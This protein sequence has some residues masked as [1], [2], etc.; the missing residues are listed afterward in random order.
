MPLYVFVHFFLYLDLSQTKVMSF[1]TLPLQ[2]QHYVDAILW[3][4]ISPA[5]IIDARFTIIKT[6]SLYTKQFS[7]G[8]IVLDENIKLKIAELIT[9]SEDAIEVV[10]NTTAYTL[11][12]KQLHTDELFA[13]VLKNSNNEGQ[14]KNIAEALEEKVQLRTVQLEQLRSFLNSILN[15]AYFGIANYEPV[16]TN[17]KITDFKINYTNQE[18]PGNFG[19]NA[20]TVIGKTFKEVY[21]G[22]FENGVFNKLKNSI[23]TQLPDTYE[24]EVETENKKIW[25]TAAIEHVNGTLTVTSKNITAEKEFALSLEKMND[26]LNAKN[27]DLASFAYIASHDLQ[28][29]IRKIRM[30]TSRILEKD[31]ANFT[32]ESE[33]YLN[34][35]MHT[36]QRMHDLVKDLLLYSKAD[37]QTPV[38]QKTNLNDL[39]QE[40]VITMQED[41]AEI[42]AEIN[43]QELPIMNVIPSQIRQV[44]FNILINAV[45][46]RR[47]N[48]P[49]QITVSGTC[50]DIDD[51]DYYKISFQDNGIGFN[52]NYKDRIFDVFQRLHGRNEYEGSG[53]GL[54]ICK[55]IMQN[56]NG[57]I[58]AQSV[59]GE[60]SVFELY[61][62]LRLNEDNL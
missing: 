43:I 12:I 13:I 36:T 37:A 49:L 46:Y 7:N 41:L 51:T 23:I 61:F 14:Y 25:L 60:G 30:F 29:P 57:T 18:V 53:V 38:I 21:P 47:Y 26:V 33:A 59:L 3:A 35:I 52:D 56:H 45:K 31:A 55:K 22:V 6:N 28:E 44:F 19:L 24:I 15:S 34:K 54:A 42:N 1:A 11:K 20:D 32:S 10:I 39:I 2:T 58:T 48:I 8:N 62:P 5:L 17:G 9:S 40:V 16:Y 4:A 27:A 50:D